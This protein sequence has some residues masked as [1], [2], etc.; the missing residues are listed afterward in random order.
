M[1]TASL[2]LSCLAPPWRWIVVVVVVLGTVFFNSKISL[3]FF[4]LF[5]LSCLQLLIFPFVSSVFLIVLWSIFMMVALR[6]LSDNS[7][8][9]VTLVLA[10]IN[11][12]LSFSLQLS[13]F[14]IQWGIFCWNLYVLGVLFWE[15]EW[16]FLTLLRQERQGYVLSRSSTR[17]PA[18]VDTEVRDKGVFVFLLCGVRV[19]TLMPLP[20]AVRVHCLFDSE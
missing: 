14:L 15:R 19:L 4:F 12:L 10:F 16:P 20:L 8:I 6:Y 3:W 17:P 5:Y 1:F 9:S 7:N 18:S 11:W 2:L 13:R